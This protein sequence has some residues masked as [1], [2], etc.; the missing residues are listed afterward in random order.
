MNFSNAPEE[1]NRKVFLKLKEI[2]RRV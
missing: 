2:L 1:S